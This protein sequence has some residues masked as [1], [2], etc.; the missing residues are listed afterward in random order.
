MAVGHTLY[1]DRIQ[2]DA[3]RDFAHVAMVMSTP[4]L[5]LVRPDFPAR[6]LAELSPA[7]AKPGDKLLPTLDR[8]QSWKEADNGAR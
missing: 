6:S 5:I 4:Y 3:D 1:R 7:K 2:W 8:T